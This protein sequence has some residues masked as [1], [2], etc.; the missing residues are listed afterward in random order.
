MPKWKGRG[1]SFLNKLPINRLMVKLKP[2]RNEPLYSNM[3]MAHWPLMG[4]CYIWYSE[5]GL[6]GLRPRLILSSMYQM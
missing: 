3:V 2:Q 6:S 4:G 5:E 1:I